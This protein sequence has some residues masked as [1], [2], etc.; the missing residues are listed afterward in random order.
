[1]EI[2]RRETVCIRWTQ[3]ASTVEN[4]FFGTLC[5]A[6][7]SMKN[8]YFYASLKCT[9]KY[10]IPPTI[11]KCYRKRKTRIF[12]AMELMVISNKQDIRKSR[13]FS[14]SLIHISSVTDPPVHSEVTRDVP[15]EF[16]EVKLAPDQREGGSPSGSGTPSSA[17]I[18]RS[19]PPQ[20][21]TLL[22]TN[23]PTAS[24]IDM[25]KSNKT[26]TDRST[27]NTAS[28]SLQNNNPFSRGGSGGGTEGG[29][30]GIFGSDNGMGGKG[31]G[32]GRGQGSG[33]GT[34][35]VRY[36]E[37]ST[38]NIYTNSE[39]KVQLILNVNEEGKV[40][41]GRTVGAGTT[42]SDQQII[43]KVMAACKAQLRYKPSDSMT[44]EY[45]TALIRPQ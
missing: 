4:T 11:L 2:Q 14:A 18:N 39:I 30:G 42:T 12:E 33:R 25:G 24:A 28:T 41:S 29:S 22:S 27:N 1:M 26:N 15:I 38:D 8:R 16:M 9:Q 5:R 20:Q 13:F 17:P 31:T 19:N 34:S 36:N 37:I 35:R 23:D 32:A 21:Q 7:F 43:G 40:V 3:S 6:G 45:Y 10:K 44:E